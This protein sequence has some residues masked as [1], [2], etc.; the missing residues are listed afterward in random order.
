[1]TQTFKGNGIDSGIYMKLSTGSLK[2]FRDSVRLRIRHLYTAN[3]SLLEKH[4][5]VVGT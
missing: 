2:Q 3:R 5:E 1:M 4:D